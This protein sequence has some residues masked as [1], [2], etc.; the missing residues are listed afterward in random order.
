[1]AGIG[2]DQNP[3]WVTQFQLCFDYRWTNITDDSSF[4]IA[5][6]VRRKRHHNFPG[7]SDLGDRYIQLKTPADLTAKTASLV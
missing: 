3:L 6:G 5:D 1:M 4:I 7:H 2:I